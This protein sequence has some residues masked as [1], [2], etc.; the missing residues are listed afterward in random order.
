MALTLAMLPKL[1]E[2]AQKRNKHG[3]ALCHKPSL[4]NVTSGLA[5][6]D[7]MTNPNSAQ[8]AS[9]E[10]CYSSS[11]TALN[12]FSIWLSKRNPDIR[13]GERLTCP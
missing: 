12:A 7:N 3:E 13:V 2:A 8:Y 11:K 4:I 10:I 1:K 5:S 9:D 6:L